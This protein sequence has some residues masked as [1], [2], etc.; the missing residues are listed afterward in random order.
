MGTEDEGFEPEPGLDLG[1][2]RAL[3]PPGTLRTGRRT[4]RTLFLVRPGDDRDAD[5]L[6][7]MVDTP[8]LAAWIV[9]AVNASEI[10]ARRDVEIA[11]VAERLKHAEA[12]LT[13]DNE[14]CRLWML[15]CASVASRNRER[16]ERAEAALE[17]L[18]PD[19]RARI[20]AA[21]QDSMDR[22]ARCKACD[23]QVDAVM[24]AI[25]AAREATP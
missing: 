10:I 2:A 9:E 25:A 11:G 23:A 24:A 17:T 6:I 8:E 12:A 20:D 3:P 16:A 4:E 5:K 21:L 7:G 13:G 19:L 15:D 18:M 1:L 22:C 14:D